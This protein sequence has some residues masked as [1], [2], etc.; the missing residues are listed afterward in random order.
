[1]V[2]AIGSALGA[3]LRWGRTIS[4][5]LAAPVTNVILRERLAERD[6]QLAELTALVARLRS[7]RGS[8]PLPPVSR[9]GSGTSRRRTKPRRSRTSTKPRATRS[10]N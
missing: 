7:E 2:T 1:M 5:A 6:I 3:M 9:S 10:R 8:D 4:R